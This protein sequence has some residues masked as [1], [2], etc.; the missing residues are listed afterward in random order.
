MKGLSIRQAKSLFGP[1]DQH[2]HLLVC[3][4]LSKV[5]CSPLE[6]ELAAARPPNWAVAL[7]L[8]AHFSP[9]GQRA[10]CHE[11][12][13]L[14]RYS[15]WATLNADLLIDLLR[16]ETPERL[17]PG[18]TDTSMHIILRE[19]LTLAGN[20]RVIGAELNVN[21]WCYAEREWRIY[22]IPYVERATRHYE[23]SNEAARIYL[24]W[25]KQ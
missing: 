11:L 23:S 3:Q 15:S 24:A 25:A 18:D 10:F 9:R 22:M 6:T 12:D 2:F 16:A 14:R 21:N 1:C 17:M 7:K 8:Q 13:F 4:A 5:D 19:A 20:T